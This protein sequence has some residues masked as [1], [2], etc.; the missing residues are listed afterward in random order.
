MK[1]RVTKTTLLAAVA[2]LVPLAFAPLL[3]PADERVEDA[4]ADLIHEMLDAQKA[5]RL[6]GATPATPV[7]VPAP[8]ACTSGF[9][10]PYPCENVDLAAVVPLAELGGVAGNDSWGWTDPVDG[11]EIAIVGTGTGVAFVDV[12]VPDR[13]VVLGRVNSVGGTRG[14]G[15]SFGSVWRDVKVDDDH[16]Y[17]VS[18]VA[19]HGMQVFDLT[20]LREHYGSVPNPTRAFETVGHNTAFGSAHNIAINEDTDTAYVVGADV[21]GGGLFMVDISDPTNPVAHQGEDGM[22]CFASDG[23]THDAQ[24]VVYEGPD[25]DYNGANGYQA[26][27][28]FNYNEDTVTIVDVT[29]KAAPAM[30]T[31]IGYDTAAYTHQGW[32][33]PDQSWVIFNDEVDEQAGTVSNT[34]T[35]M[36]DVTDLDL[37]FSDADRGAVVTDAAGA[38]L[39]KSYTHESVSTDHNL[40]ITDDG[41]IWQANYNRGL[42]IL[43]EG[44]DGFEN[45]DLDEI[46]YFEV[47]SL[48]DAPHYGDSWNVYPYFGSGTVI[49]SNIG[50]GLVVLR[51]DYEAL[52]AG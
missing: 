47:D 43:R 38:P 46:G 3:Q 50:Q 37:G 25:P 51:P 33:T 31:R 7:E 49:V 8:A 36:V 13:P 28:C 10:G 45:G 12:T 42:R 40:Y 23:Y 19:G 44:P 17:I 21:C 35:Y 22:G 34:T 14:T 32:L 24:C 41:L 11:N 16:A 15:V 4:K 52:R 29:D 18:E 27:I 9:A 26:E 1:P 20:Q 30:L 39:V 6:A 48:A 5:E 2:L